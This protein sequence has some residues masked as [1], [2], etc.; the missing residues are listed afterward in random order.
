MAGNLKTVSINSVY[1][2]FHEITKQ[3]NDIVAESGVQEGLCVLNC[4]HTTAGIT[5]NSFCD[6]R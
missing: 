3:L 2:G 5:V 6:P 1:N 4:N